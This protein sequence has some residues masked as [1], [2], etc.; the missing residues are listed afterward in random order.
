MSSTGTPVPFDIHVLLLDVI[1]VAHII[2]YL[3]NTALDVT[4]VLLIFRKFSLYVVDFYTIITGYC[5]GVGIVQSFLCTA[6]VFGSIVRP[7]LIINIP[8]SCT[9]ALWLKQRYVVAK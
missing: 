4:R 8:D 7:H 2:T 1:V 3:I 5:Y 9:R 6:A